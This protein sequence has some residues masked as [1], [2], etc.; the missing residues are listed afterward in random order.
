MSN[1]PPR[2]V[3]RGDSHLTGFDSSVGHCHRA[4]TLIEL[5]VVIAIIAILAALLLPALSR[6]QA[7]ALRTACLSNFKQINLLMQYYTDDN[8]EIFPAHRNSGLNT[9]DATYS[10]TNWW[11]TTIL[12]YKTNL[13]NLFHD[14]AIHAKRMDDGTTWTWSFDCNNVGYGYNGY[15]LGHHPYEPGYDITVGG[16]RFN[17]PA[18]FKRTAVLRPA[19]SLVVG[20]KEPYGGTTPAWGSS[21][22]WESS[23]MDPNVVRFSSFATYEGVEPKRHLGQG[24]VAFNDGHAETRKS[25]RINP[26]ANP[27]D[28]SAKALINS[29]FWD[30]LQRAGPQ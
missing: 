11:G 5:L 9:D 13:S 3:H 8:T 22:W 10:L 27:A 26:P 4:F 21:L 24:A 1:K 25:E 30:P 14:P 12:G 6:A 20:D 17:G 19:D 2:A 23:C 18:V 29:R 7:K 28:H 16:V 15:F